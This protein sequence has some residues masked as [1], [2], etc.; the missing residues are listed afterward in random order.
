MVDDG[1]IDSIPDF[2]VARGM[3]RAIGANLT[4]ALRTRRLSRDGLDRMI[5]V[6]AACPHKGDCL[7][8]L[9]LNAAGAVR[10][11]AYC[12]NAMAFAALA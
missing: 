4:G 10:P 1:L 6:C 3:G 12:M 5:G 7:G 2:W 11:P 9:A 8:W